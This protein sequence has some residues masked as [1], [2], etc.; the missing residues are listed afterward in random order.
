MRKKL[1]RFT[2]LGLIAALLIWIGVQGMDGDEVDETAPPE[3]GSRPVLSG[4][5]RPDAETAALAGPN[6]AAAQVADLFWGE[7]QVM[8]AGLSSGD[9]QSAWRAQQHAGEILPD[10]H[11][12]DAER[13]RF[14]RLAEA[15]DAE[16]QRRGREAGQ[17]LRLQRVLAA[18]QLLRPVL[19]G[20]DG[21]RERFLG[22]GSPEEGFRPAIAVTATGLPPLPEPLG[23]G[24]Q[25]R[26][27]AGDRLRFGQVIRSSS[28]RATLRLRT[29]EG[30]LYPE[31]E[32]HHLGLVNPTAAE[33]MDQALRC[34]HAG[35]ALLAS[36]WMQLVRA[37]GE[38]Q[39][40]RARAISACLGR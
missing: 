24:R 3:H 39:S 34:L 22:F 1:R 27:L 23:T 17:Q 26:M 15:F 18:N 16:L 19:S 11:Q 7:L 8:E 38:G 33:S 13:A 29:A 20:D 9:L 6:P 32:L 4:A 12:E 37:M 21:L 28:W 5:A 30:L 10:I 14:Q 2:G 40:E 31:V 36:L 25:V 35:D